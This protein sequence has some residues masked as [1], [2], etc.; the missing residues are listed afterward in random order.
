M[1]DAELL[2]ILCCPETHQPLRPADS[3][4]IDSLNR[5][6]AAGQLR[7][8]VGTILAE[9]LEGGFVR[10]DGKL[11]YPVRHGL[12]ILLADEAVPLDPAAAL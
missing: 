8:R 10:T 11:L 5:Q 12:P 2:K 4:L 1:A 9:K 3:S 6:I 7:N